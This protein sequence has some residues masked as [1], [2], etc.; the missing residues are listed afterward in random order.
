MLFNVVIAFNLYLLSQ[1]SCVKSEISSAS[2]PMEESVMDKMAKNIK[3][4]LNDISE[5]ELREWARILL[6]RADIAPRFN[7]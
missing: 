7:A 5:A 6:T 1:Y 3:N 4:D 2:N